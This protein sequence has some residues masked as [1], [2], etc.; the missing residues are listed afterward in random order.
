MSEPKSIPDAVGEQR[1]QREASA[2]P[3]AAPQAKN[4]SMPPTQPTNGSAITA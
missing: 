4:T 1:P 2:A 3:S